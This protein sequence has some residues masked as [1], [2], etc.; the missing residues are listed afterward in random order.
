M[1]HRSA[2][3]FIDRPPPTF[4]NLQLSGEAPRWPLQIR[5]DQPA[6]LQGLTWG[7]LLSSRLLQSVFLL[8][9]GQL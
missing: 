3:R 6:Q 5:D 2:A 9:P 1:A 7:K 4:R 8:W